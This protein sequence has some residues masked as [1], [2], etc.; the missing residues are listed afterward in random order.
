MHL[1]SSNVLEQPE[2]FE[3]DDGQ[4]SSFIAYATQVHDDP[5]TSFLG[6]PLLFKVAS[7]ARRLTTREAVPW[8]IYGDL[9]QLSREWKADRE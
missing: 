9:G 8:D 6:V 7:D 5:P 1:T 3:L 4:V 2:I